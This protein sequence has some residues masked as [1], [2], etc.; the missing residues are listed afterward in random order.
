MSY[1]SAHFANQSMKSEIQK[2]LSKDLNQSN[3]TERLVIMQSE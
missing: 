3:I 2:D 1:S